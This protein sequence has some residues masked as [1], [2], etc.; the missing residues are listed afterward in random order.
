MDIASMVES[1]LSTLTTDVTMYKEGDHRRHPLPPTTSRHLR[2][3]RAHEETRMEL[4]KGNRALAFRHDVDPLLFSPHIIDSLRGLR[5][6]PVQSLAHHPT[7]VE[8]R[9]AREFRG[10]G[11]IGNILSRR[12]AAPALAQSVTCHGAARPPF[13]DHE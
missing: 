12:I 4:A 8:Y 5:T 13:V 7:L 1:V 6:N 2:L 3:L 10:A 11:S 9:L